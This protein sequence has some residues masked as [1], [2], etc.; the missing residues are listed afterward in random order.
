MATLRIPKPHQT[1]LE[2]LL[3][4][5]EE[6]ANA[7]FAALEKAEPMLLPKNLEEQIAPQVA[8][9]PLEDLRQILRVALG[10]HQASAATG[11][12]REEFAEEICKA[13]EQSKL[14]DAKLISDKR[15]VFK[16]RVLRLLTFDVS[17]GVTSKALDVMTE[18][19]RI[20]CGARVMTDV[21]PVFTKAAEKPAAALVV[22]TLKVSYHQDGEHRD[23]YVAMDEADVRRMK[24]LLERAEIKAQSLKAVLE[25][26]KIQHLD[27]K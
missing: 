16:L 8:G 10:L 25:S 21:R 17:L 14:E 23:F 9:I 5:G 3:A 4:L 18:H 1:G 19:E 2:K 7:L 26:A 20:L 11:M 22:H 27:M 12:L 6:Q 15:D 24:A 13:I